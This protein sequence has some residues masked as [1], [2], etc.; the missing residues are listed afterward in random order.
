[1]C[2]TWVP[3]C[4]RSWVDFY[5]S[6]PRA[7]FLV[8]TRLRSEKANEWLTRSNVASCGRPRR[9]GGAIGSPSATVKVNDPNSKVGRELIAAFRS[10]D[11]LR[12]SVRGMTPHTEVK[13]S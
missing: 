13:G 7:F 1:M 9:R 4:G 12:T 11:P 6:N 5:A 3:A 8:K 2:G 10:S